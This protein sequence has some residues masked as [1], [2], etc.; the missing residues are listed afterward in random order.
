M[1][2]MRGDARYRRRHRVIGRKLKPQQRSDGPCILLLVN[3]R[4]CFDLAFGGYAWAHGQEVGLTRMRGFRAVIGP[5]RAYAPAMVGKD[6]HGGLILVKRVL[7]QD[8]PDIPEG[9]IGIMSRV[10]VIAIVPVMPE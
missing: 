1:I 9:G 5:V 8:S 3:L 6:Q 2:L 7:L 4:R 10:E